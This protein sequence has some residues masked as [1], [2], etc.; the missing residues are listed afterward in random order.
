MLLCV[1]GDVCS[2]AVAHVFV[3]F[4]SSDPAMHM[5]LLRVGESSPHHINMKDTTALMIECVRKHSS[6]AIAIDVSFVEIISLVCN[7]SINGNIKP[8]TQ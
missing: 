3:N 5:I 7:H 8:N 6:H 1:D 4:C 2:L